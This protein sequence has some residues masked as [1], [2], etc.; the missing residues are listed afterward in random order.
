MNRYPK[1]LGVLIFGVLHIAAI[2]MVFESVRD[3]PLRMEAF[4]GVGALLAA[5]TAVA[6]YRRKR[7]K[8]EFNKSKCDA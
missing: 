6:I 1:D 2:S 8:S 7:N 4:F 5:V 3:L